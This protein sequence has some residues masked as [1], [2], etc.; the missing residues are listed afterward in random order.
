MVARTG[1]F[2][3]SIPALMGGTILTP[4]IRT[5]LLHTGMA[6]IA[7]PPTTET[8]IGTA[9][10]IGIGMGTG[11]ATGMTT[12]VIDPFRRYERAVPTRSRSRYPRYDGRCSRDF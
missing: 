7:G 5:M 8:I 9:A 3:A 10:T 6:T 2:T 4:P 11:T 1:Q 12:I